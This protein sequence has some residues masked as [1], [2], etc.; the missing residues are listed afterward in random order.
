[1]IRST[2]Q[3]VERARDPRRF[4]GYQQQQAQARRLLRSRK[5]QEQ[6]LKA[7][8]WRL[9][10]GVGAVRERAK[11]AEQIAARRGGHKAQEKAA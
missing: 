6:Q 11:L 9:G 7:L 2:E 8:D 1:M 10:L 4:A 5:T 3:Y